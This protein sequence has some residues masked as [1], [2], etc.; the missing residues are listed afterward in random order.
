MI[1]LRIVAVVAVLG[2]L[3]GCGGCLGPSGASPTST[4]SKSHR[5]EYSL[6][7]EWGRPVNGLRC[8]LALSKSTFRPDETPSFR[9]DLQNVSARPINIVVESRGW[10]GRVMIDSANKMGWV[11]PAGK[12]RN[13]CRALKPE[14]IISTSDFAAIHQVSI[15]EGRHVF[16]GEYSNTIEITNPSFDG[17]AGTGIKLWIGTDAIHVATSVPVEIVVES[18]KQQ[19]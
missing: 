11:P 19:K 4:N 7:S 3:C 18:G 8:R 9:L 6:V 10:F 15:A 12:F 17:W 13:A 16:T 5:A 14:E 1:S 2:W